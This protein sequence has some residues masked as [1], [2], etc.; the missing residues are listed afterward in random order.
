PPNPRQPRQAQRQRARL[1][2]TPP[3]TRQRVR[4]RLHRPPLPNDRR[5]RRTKKRTHRRR[6]SPPRTRLQNL[7]SPNRENARVVIPIP[8]PSR[9]RLGEGSVV[10]ERPGEGS[11]LGRGCLVAIQVTAITSDPNNPDDEEYIV[12]LVGQVVRVSVETVKIVNALP[13][14]YAAK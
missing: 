7:E 6:P 4:L 3:K 13:K 1:Q 9:E 12:H 8:L 14:E 11:A 2:Q 5:P 10:G